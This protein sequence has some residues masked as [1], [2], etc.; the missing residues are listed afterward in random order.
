MFKRVE[1][2][3]APWPVK[4]RREAAV[5]GDKKYYTGS[6][7]AK[8]HVSQRHVN[9]G[10]CISCVSGYAREY[11]N[12][13]RA[14]TVGLVPLGDW[15]VRP[16]NVRAISEFIEALRQAR[17]LAGEPCGPGVYV[18]KFDEKAVRKYIASIEQIQTPDEGGI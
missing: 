3:P 13:L 17:A 5:A 9:S 7:C 18:H 8:G 2:S 12:T 6:T 16:D 10:A 4:T 11:K 1:P 15:F 14:A